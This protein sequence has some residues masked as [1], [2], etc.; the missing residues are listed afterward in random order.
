MTKALHILYIED[1]NADVEL[2]TMALER[3]AHSTNIILDVTETVEEAKILFNA[4]RHIIALIDC[5]LPDGEGSEVV[6][7]IKDKC[8]S[9]PILLLSGMLTVKHLSLEKQYDN[10]VCLDKNYNK[11][12]IDKVIQYTK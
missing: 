6:Q 11:A 9:F 12:F 8:N 2:L 4:E 7:F 1:N 5:N 10:L 3:Y